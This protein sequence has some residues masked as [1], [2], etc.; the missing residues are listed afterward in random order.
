MKHVKLLRSAQGLP[1]T[2][3]SKRSKAVKYSTCMCCDQQD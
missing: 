3:K 2:V 1:K